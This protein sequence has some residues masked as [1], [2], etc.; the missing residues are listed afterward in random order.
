[1]NCGNFDILF[2]LHSLSGRSNEIISLTQRQRRKESEEKE[3]ERK[4]KK[5]ERKLTQ[6]MR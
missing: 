2:L 6:A 3:K 4:W 1:M 5:S